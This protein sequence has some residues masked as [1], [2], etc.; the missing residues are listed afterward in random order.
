MVLCKAVTPTK[1]VINCQSQFNG[2]V[3][4]RLFIQIRKGLAGK[5]LAQKD[6]PH[7]YNSQ[8]PGQS[9]QLE[10][11]D[12]LGTQILIGHDLRFTDASGHESGYA[13]N[14]SKVYGMAAFHG[15]DHLDAPF[16]F[17]YL[18]FNPSSRSFGVKG[19]IR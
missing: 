8:Q 11:H 4:S 18:P 12:G 3:K 7:G 6:L 10:S 1:I 9:N 5:Y 15:V 13:A 19:A 16:A 14:R 2:L 17:A